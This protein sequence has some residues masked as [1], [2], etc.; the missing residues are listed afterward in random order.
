MKLLDLS[1]PFDPDLYHD[2]PD[3]KAELDVRAV[4]TLQ[5][6]GV[7]SLK[8]TIG[9]HLGT[10]IDAPL[11]LVE[12]GASIDDL[13]LDRFYGS[14]VI[15]DIPKDPNGGVSAA[16]LEAARPAVEPGDIVI[17]ATGWGDRISD[18]QYASHHP[19]L[20]EDGADWLVAKSPRLVGIDVQSVDLP[21]TL[22]APGFA[23]T[24]LR[25]LLEHGVPALHSVTNLGPISG[26]RVTV[27]ALPIAF[28]DVD[29]APARVVAQLDD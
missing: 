17:I 22:R 18:P 9:N 2:R 27:F 11:H 6:H 16:D 29:G 26:R 4:K 25:I 21:H 12:G 14:A 3:Q 13:S 7:N 28:A 10:H 8:I 19:Y 23:Y 1:H 5:E 20:T 24:S 15:L